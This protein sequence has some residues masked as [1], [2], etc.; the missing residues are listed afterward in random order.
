MKEIQETC[1]Y[2]SDVYA[3]LTTFQAIPISVENVRILSLSS[4]LSSTIFVKISTSFVVSLVETAGTF[5]MLQTPACRVF[6]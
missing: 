4:V 3:F 5:D 2:D 1:E 6:F